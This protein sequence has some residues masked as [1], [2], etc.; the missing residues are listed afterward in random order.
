MDL[1][2]NGSQSEWLN[3]RN[4]QV[5][6]ER[7]NGNRHLASANSPQAF[8]ARGVACAAKHPL[9]TAVSYAE[10]AEQIGRPSWTRGSDSK[11]S[12]SGTGA[13]SRQTTMMNLLKVLASYKEVGRRPLLLAMRQPSRGAQRRYAGIASAGVW[14]ARQ[15]A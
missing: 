4:Q 2:S 6:R 1:G 5:L 12:H 11:Q 3:A 10:V 9:R 14:Q 7:V 15:T 8:S 13:V